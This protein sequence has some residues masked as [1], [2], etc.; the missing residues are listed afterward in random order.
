[1]NVKNKV[2]LITGGGTGVGRA[3]ALQLA[4][5]G[6]SVVVNY[7]KSRAEAEQTASDVQDFGVR[8]AAIQADVRDDNAVRDLVRETVATMQRLDILVCSAGKTSFIPASDLDSVTD[9]VWNDI[10]DVNVQGVF[11]AARAARPAMLQSGGGEIVS[12]SSVAGIVGSGSCIPYCAAKAAVINLTVALAKVFAP[13]IR[14]NSVAPGFIAGSWL[15]K[16]LGENYE[17]VRASFESA[18]PLG[19]VCTPQDVAS[20]VLGVVCG[21]DMVTGQTTVCDGGMTIAGFSAAIG[22]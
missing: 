13:E 3:T 7:S 21:S 19:R 12:I 17:R 5:H 2:A 9:E 6:C 11:R 14:V 20:A 10:M 18:L 8:G 16:G 15:E 1:M 22:K 4:E